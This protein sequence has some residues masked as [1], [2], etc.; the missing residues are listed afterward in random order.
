MQERLEE[1]KGALDLQVIQ[2][3]TLRD[4]L[5]R[6]NQVLQKKNTENAELQRQ[7]QEE[8]QK[9]ESERKNSAEQE[10]K[11][12]T[13]YRI[14]L[15]NRKREIAKLS[16]QLVLKN[17]LLS[18][19]GEQCQKNLNQIMEFYENQKKLNEELI[20]QKGYVNRLIQMNLKIQKSNQN[21]DVAIIE[22]KS[23][24]EKLEHELATLRVSQ[25]SKDAYLTQIILNIQ[26]INKI[27]DSDEKKGMKY[28]GNDVPSDLKEINTQIQTLMEKIE[29]MTPNDS[30]EKM[31][32]EAFDIEEGHKK[33]LS[34]LK[35]IIDT[36]NARI[37]ELEKEKKGADEVNKL[38]L[39]EG[40][41]NANEIGR[42]TAEI[43]RQKDILKDF[44]E[45]KRQLK[46]NNNVIIGLTQSILYLQSENA[47]LKTG[48]DVLN[49]QLENKNETDKKNIDLTRKLL[50][51]KFIIKCL[52]ESKNKLKNGMESQ[53]R[54]LEQ[55]KLVLEQEDGKNKLTI[56]HQSAE[57]ER[58][59][60]E[61]LQS[62]EN[63]RAIEQQL[64]D[65][66]NQNHNIFQ[67]MDVKH[68]EDFKG[69]SD[70]FK[71][72]THKINLLTEENKTLKQTNE[73]NGAQ[74]L[75]DYKEIERI[76]DDNENLKAE[77]EKLKAEKKEL[78]DIIMKN[79]AEIKEKDTLIEKQKK[80]FNILNNQYSSEIQKLREDL[81]L[82]QNDNIGLSQQL[83]KIRD[84]TAKTKQTEHEI[85]QMY[86]QNLSNQGDENCKN[87]IIEMYNNRLDEIKVDQTYFND[88]IQLFRN[89]NFEQLFEQ[90]NINSEDF[91]E[92][93]IIPD[94]LQKLPLFD[95]KTKLDSLFT[96]GNN[97][98]KILLSNILKILTKHSVLFKYCYL[99]TDIEIIRKL[100]SDINVNLIEKYLFHIIGTLYK[101]IREKYEKLKTEE[102][103]F[104]FLNESKN[105]REYQQHL[106]DIPFNYELDISFI[107]KFLFLI[108]EI[109][110]KKYISYINDSRRVADAQIIANV[111]GLIEAN[112]YEPDDTSGNT[113]YTIIKIE[114]GLEAI[115]QIDNLKDA[116]PEIND[117]KTGKLPDKLESQ[118][119]I[120]T[121]GGGI[122]DTLFLMFFNKYVCVLIILLLV[123]LYFYIKCQRQK[124]NYRKSH[125]NYLLTI[126]QNLNMKSYIQ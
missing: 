18:L 97:K 124:T 114:K 101:K 80:S 100:V 4:E 125:R 123:L 122:A 53:I 106:D 24:I 92:S 22:Q 98:I 65:I 50:M 15:R 84:K 121:T 82:L 56:A 1:G 16:G 93:K 46:I 61:N 86:N 34:V 59:Q 33:N 63:K 110:N 72:L 75:S 112:L 26:Q 17:R 52:L 79:D 105:K 96:T 91:M 90:L 7:L 27:D 39:E 120:P 104:E 2:I 43:E 57:I 107:D 6:G 87:L 5:I 12:F 35:N 10:S 54:E 71:N 38:A 42:L 99:S 48:N 44:E 25:E 74:L 102:D 109:Y 14:I 67:L 8:G 115:L 41:R 85:E 62:Q 47:R 126:N 60:R 36:Q 37:Q 89:N 117:S 45:N 70:D 66:H 94:V 64:T 116:I 20:K 77:N 28:E 103:I 30:V 108:N 81:S 51:S 9:L 113:F 118:D 40:G 88:I 21:K 29:N 78:E 23:K 73:E 76:K 83:Q 19:L 119:T 69:L 3:A 11:N 58:L 13:V 32:A 111:Q 55:K 68:S 31:R 49:K 95:I